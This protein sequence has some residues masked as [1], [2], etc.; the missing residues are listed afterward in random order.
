MTHIN[1]MAGISMRNMV[2]EVVGR[3]FLSD[4]PEQA[5]MPVLPSEG[6]LL[7]GQTFLSDLKERTD[8]NVCST[9][10]V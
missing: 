9:E 4:P 10:C 5:R 3:T 1:I 7:E 2:D 6:L 8:K